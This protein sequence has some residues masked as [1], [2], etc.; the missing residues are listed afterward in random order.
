MTDYLGGE[1]GLPR[2]YW[3]NTSHNDI[4]RTF[5]G[6]K[7][8]KSVPGKFE[9]LM[10]GGTIRQTLVDDLTYEGLAAKGAGSAMDAK[11]REDSFWSIL[12]MTGYL[13]KADPDQDGA[14]VD[15]KI[16]NKEIAALFQSAVVDHF[17]A[18]LDRHILRGMMEALWK[19]DDRT[20]S[21]LISDLLWKTISYN[22]YHEDFYHAF[23]TG[24]FTGLEYNLKTDREYGLGRPDIVLLDDDNRRA[25]VIEAKMA[26]KAEKSENIEDNLERACADALQQIADQRYADGV[27]LEGYED[28][29]CYGIGFSGKRVMVKKLCQATV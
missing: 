25:L 20:A 12:L 24:I 1:S 15:L 4:I 28:I 9:A 16:P 27:A 5:V 17:T 23:L 13:T 26:K 3:A 2:N 10:N 29:I 18:T 14:T 6:D 11:K 21:K 7:T 19:G 22:N 8:L